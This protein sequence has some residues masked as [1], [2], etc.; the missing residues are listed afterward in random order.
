MRILITGGGTGGHV[1]PAI[2]VADSI[3]KRDPD[4]EIA[5][6]GTSRGIENKLVPAAGYPL[7][8]VNVIGIRRS[9]SPRNIKALWLALTYPLKASRIVKKFKPDVVFG[10]GGYVSWPVIVAASRKKIPTALHEAN[11]VPGLAI[12][13][14]VPYT[15]RIFLNF[16][17]GERGLGAGAEGKTLHVGCP[18]RSG[19]GKISREEAR[20]RL[21]IDR[22]TFMIL[23]F[24]GSLGAARLNEAAFGLIAEYVCKHPEVTYLHAT[25]DGYYRE[26]RERFLASGYDTYRN[27]KLER[28]IENMALQLAAADLVICRSGAITLAELSRAGRASILIPSP[29]VTDNQ[30]YRNARVIA[31]CGGAVLIEEKDLTEEKLENAIEEIKNDRRL[32]LSMESSVRSISPDDAETVIC[33]ELFA[34]AR[35][36]D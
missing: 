9:L 20:D 2:A 12:R 10:T 33:D 21:G 26:Y 35:K 24:G 28:Y 13:K 27:I 4:A 6:V 34:L 23:S 17:A 7:Y 18:L 14:L 5:F 29:N 11:A 30:Q 25:G 32:R 16:K 22:G 8:H 31:D 3:K 1:N 19:I 15:D 36:K